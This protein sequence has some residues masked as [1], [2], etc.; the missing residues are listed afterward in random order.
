MTRRHVLAAV[1]ALAPISAQALEIKT[2]PY[3]QNVTS[4]GMTVMWETDEAA[5]GALYTW[6]DGVWEQLSHGGSSFIHQ[7]RIEG[8]EPSETLP[9]YVHSELD[10]VEVSSDSYEL[11]SAPEDHSAFTMTVWGD[12]QWGDD[13]VFSQLVQGD[14]DTE[15]MAGFDPD[16]LIGVGDVVDNGAEYWQWES[17]LLDPL[18][19]LAASVPF[20]TAI[21]NHEVDSAWFYDYLDQ[22]GNEHWFAFDYGG[23]RLV[24]VDTN[25][26][27]TPGSEQYDWLRE[28]LSSEHTQAADWIFTFHHHPPYSEIYEE[29]IY[30]SLRTHLVPL[31]EAAGVDINFTGHIHDYERG[32]YLPED[33]GRRIAYI[34]TSGGGGTLWWDEYD[35]DWPQIEQVIQWTYHFMVLDI[36]ADQLSLR[37]IDIDGD[38][39]DSLEMIR[40]DREFSGWPDQ[41]EATTQWDFTE[42]DLIPSYGPGTMDYIWGES[43]ETAAQTEFGQTYELGIAPIGGEP[44]AVMGFPRSVGSDMGFQVDHAAGPN[45]G[46]VYV[47]EFSLVLDLLI[48][49][50][51]F[52]AD[53]WLA[54]LNTAYES[55]NEADVFVSLATG[56]VGISGQYDGELLPDSWHR[57]ALVFSVEGN[58]LLQKYID[59]VPVGS[60]DLGGIDGRW[61][62]YSSWDS[63][64]TFTFLSDYY[65]DSTSGYVSSV[66]FTDRALSAE[67]IVELGGPDADGILAE[68]PDEEPGDTAEPDVEDTEQPEDSGEPPDEDDSPRDTGGEVKPG[69]GDCGCVSGAA[70]GSLWG[71]LA[72]LA[73]GGGRRRA[74]PRRWA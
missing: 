45:G 40:E 73:W 24:V 20:A 63:Y 2:G 6:R 3:L 34:Q 66:L 25:Y 58:Q 18:Q 28:E 46:G 69:G 10:G 19:P 21:G 41:V 55:Y 1:V 60:Q 12:N 11:T 30:A 71:L 13:T 29:S 74:S 27:F 44:A 37:A 15:G 38:E 59:G 53:S 72:L 57:L 48:P 32:V 31:Y 47:N 62:L 51:S 43:S 68:E 35:G 50:R 42:G 7:V 22:P 61:S 5:S 8:L 67:E 39:I 65:G 36:G 17:Q 70:P 26:D 49:E 4:D 56:G 14:L 33:S 54:I 52:E 16:L 23:V 9:Y 64:P